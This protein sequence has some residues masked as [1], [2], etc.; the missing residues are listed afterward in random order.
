MKELIEQIVKLSNTSKEGHI[1]SSLS[2]L[3]ILYILYKDFI[4]NTVEKNLGNRFI[5]SKGHASL[6][7]YVI[8]NVFN[9]LEE[10]LENFCKFDS[11]IGGHPSDKINA[12]DASTGSLGHGLP[13][14]IG[15]AMGYKILKNSN[16]IYCLIGDGE[17]NEGTIWESL[18][19]A[20]NHNLNNLTC[21]LDYNHSND[22]ALKLD[23]ISN[24]INAFN[25]NCIEIDGHN[26]DQIKS[27]LSIK[28]DN[29]PTFIIANTIKGKGIS[30]MENSPEWHHKFPNNIELQQILTELYV[31]K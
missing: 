14:A 6:A 15:M 24:K 28:H 13:I 1:A 26:Q 7:Y 19:L 27:S 22:R 17:M 10:P 20:S 16:H 11:L 23:N 18:L 29:K 2:I 9:L 5:L 4:T 8:L 31:Y 12:V 30:C 25:W 3:D 21:I